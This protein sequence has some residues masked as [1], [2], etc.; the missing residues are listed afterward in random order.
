MSPLYYTWSRRYIYFFKNSV[1]NIKNDVQLKQYFFQSGMEFIIS[2][3]YFNWIK[4]TSQFFLEY[5][6]ETQAQSLGGVSHR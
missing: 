5:V 6:H 4:G 2:V 1:S 3:P